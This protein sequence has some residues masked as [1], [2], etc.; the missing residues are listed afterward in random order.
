MI[1]F[2]EVKL[3]QE[4]VKKVDPETNKEYYTVETKGYLADGMYVPLE[5][6]NRHYQE[7]QEWIKQG[8]TPTPQYTDEDVIGYVRNQ[9]LNK[10]K[11]DF[12]NLPSLGYESQA[13]GKKINA[14]Y[15]DLQNMKSLLEY[16]QANNI[17]KVQF[18]C[19]DNS[20]VEI[21]QDQLQ[22]AINELIAYGIKCY[23]KKWNIEQKIL[24]ATTQDELLSIK[25]D[26]Y[27]NL[28]ESE[29]TSTSSTTSTKE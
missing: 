16:M 19:Y 23:Q 1:N 18:R 25:W 12:K 24:A 2:N 10:L 9:L 13:I 6:S 11:Q 14:T 5:P 17:D 21:T 26:E 15:V 29:D 8:N 4:I 27:L 22:Q 7:I 3:V 20:F 28:I